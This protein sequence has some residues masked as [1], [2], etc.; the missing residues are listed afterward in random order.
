MSPGH[1]EKLTTSTNFRI[2]AAATLKFMQEHPDQTLQKM[3]P[4]SLTASRRTYT[5][6]QLRAL[7]PVPLEPP[8]QKSCQPTIEEAE[9]P[10]PLQPQC[11]SIHSELQPYPDKKASRYVRLLYDAFSFNEAKRNYGTYKRELKAIVTFCDKYQH[12]LTSLITSTIFTDH[13]PLLGFLN[14]HAEGIY[15]RW[16]TT[17]RGLDIRFEYIEGH[18]NIVADDLSRTI[19][20]EGSNGKAVE[21]AGTRRLAE[22]LGRHK[23][24]KGSAAA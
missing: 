17:L 19:F 13:R 16:Q 2:A 5:N 22:E 6:A 10:P 24:N 21:T 15:A 12:W 8:A 3:T 18:R 7:R 20:V 11:L 1:D 14:S 23:D 4:S 9:E